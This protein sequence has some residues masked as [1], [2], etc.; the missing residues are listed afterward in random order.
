MGRRHD[1]CS[2]GLASRRHGRVDESM[3]TATAMHDHAVT[4][5]ASG[6]I[7]VFVRAHVLAHVP[8]RSAA[9][10]GRIRFHGFERPAT[11]CSPTTRSPNLNETEPTVIIT[12]VSNKDFCPA[13]RSSFRTERFSRSPKSAPRRD[14]R[15]QSLPTQFN[16]LQDI[17]L[18]K[19]ESR[20][21]ERRC[22][23]LRLVPMAKKGRPSCSRS[24]ICKN[25]SGLLERLRKAQIPSGLY[26]LYYKEPGLPPQMVLE[27]RKTGNTIGDP[28]REPGRG[29]NPVESQPQ[30]PTADRLSAG[31]SA[32][33]AATP[34]GRFQ[35]PDPQSAESPAEA[36]ITSAAQPSFSRA[37]AS[38]AVGCGSAPAPTFQ[39]RQP[40]HPTHRTTPTI[41]RDS[42]CATA[43][44]V[45]IRIRR[46]GLSPPNCPS[47]DREFTVSDIGAA[48]D[49]LRHRRLRRFEAE[50]AAACVA[51][52][53]HREKVPARC[54][55]PASGQRA[56]SMEQAK[57]CNRPLVAFGSMN[58]PNPALSARLAQ[59]D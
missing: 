55:H 13:R 49:R 39:Y 57:P 29:T 36:A 9:E 50:L 21:T 51:A 35:S 53:R 3:P 27:F 59:D 45:D 41:R 2:D 37:A 5:I 11:S 47:C 23:W 4:P 22:S 17:G 25:I 33:P 15:Y 46:P 38:C 19:P 43:P 52:D 54:S 56:S 20:K 58:W 10:Q 18:G 31:R 16:R 30:R 26:R 40:K 12:T 28:V 8:R 1:E 24:P 14:P 34:M 32:N 44:I 48:D 42:P 7:H 6:P